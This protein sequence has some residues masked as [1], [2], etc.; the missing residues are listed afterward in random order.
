MCGRFTLTAEETEIL[1]RFQLEHEIGNYEKRYNIAPSQQVLAVINDGATNRAGYLK[2]GL[3]P[4]WAKDP[5]IGSKM[6]NARGETL[7]EKPSFRSSYR[8]KRC[9]IVADG[10]Y[11]WKREGNKKIP[12][13][14]SL[15][16]KSLFSF[17]GLWETFTLEDG[18]PLNTCT[19][20]TT[21]PNKLVANVHDRMPVILT[22]ESE[23]TWL[24]RSIQDVNILQPLITPYHDELMTYYEVST[25]VNSSKNEGE[26][27]LSN[28]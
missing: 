7:A 26:Q 16:D 23:E 12:M 21:K 1:E 15:K 17:A 8:R 5:A 25:L 14:I 2:W 6:I 11:E 13:Y 28:P 10:F 4:P 3:V 9:L 24:D 27:L 19:I 18:K 20:I 22:K